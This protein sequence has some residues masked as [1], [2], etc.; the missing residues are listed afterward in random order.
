M[1]CSKSSTDKASSMNSQILR[2]HFSFFSYCITG[3]LERNRNP[4]LIARMRAHTQSLG[5][6]EGQFCTNDAVVIS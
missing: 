6:K 5:A 1:T 3:L 4:P 2:K